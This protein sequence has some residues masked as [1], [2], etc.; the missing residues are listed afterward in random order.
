MRTKRIIGCEVKGRASV[1]AN[2]PYEQEWKSKLEQRLREVKPLGYVPPQRFSIKIDF[3]IG[4]SRIEKGNDLDNL[5]KPVLDTL[6]KVGFIPDDP[7]VYNLEL[8]K[9]I[10]AEEE[11]ATIDMWE[12]LEGR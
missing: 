2:P 6:V 10:T 7:K 5:A 1:W 9:H 8:T 4:R 3:Y 12:W 11:S